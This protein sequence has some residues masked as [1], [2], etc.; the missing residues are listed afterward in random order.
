M[1]DQL[2]SPRFQALF[3]SALV[4]YEEKTG[5][6][7][8]KHPLG[9]QLQKCQ[10]V[11]SITTLLQGQARAFSKYR[12]G[13]KIMQSLKSVVSVLYRVSAVAAQGHSIG[14]VCP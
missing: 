8:A 2:G 4:D 6:S 13:D 3:K 1:S 5:I 9:K 12:G 10:S 14:I 11:E 7:L